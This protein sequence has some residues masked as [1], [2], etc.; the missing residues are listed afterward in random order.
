MTRLRHL[1]VAASDMDQASRAEGLAICA[2]L[3]ALLVVA[4][5][6]GPS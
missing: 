5:M 4:S 3:L 2:L 6:G 1:V